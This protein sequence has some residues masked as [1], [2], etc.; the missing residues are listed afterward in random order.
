MKTTTH[1]SPLWELMTDHAKYRFETRIKKRGYSL[2]DLEEDMINA[3]VMIGHDKVTDIFIGKLA[4][5]IT[6][7]KTGSIITIAPKRKLPRKKTH[8]TK[9]L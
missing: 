4:R 5:Y 6:D 8:L 3:K 9:K 2:S 7:S 1:L